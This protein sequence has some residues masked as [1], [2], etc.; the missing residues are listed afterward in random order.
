MDSLATVY[1]AETLAEGCESCLRSRGWDGY[2]SLREVSPP[3]PPL[4][5]SGGPVKLP[6][7]RRSRVGGV[8]GSVGTGVVGWL[9]WWEGAVNMPDT[10]NSTSAERQ[11]AQSKSTHSAHNKQS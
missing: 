8:S 9:V 1:S 5:P 11:E 6:G 4:P 10:L 7:R 2:L 3:P